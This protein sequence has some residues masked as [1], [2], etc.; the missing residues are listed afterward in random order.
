VALDNERCGGPRARAPAIAR[1]GSVCCRREPR[2]RARALRDAA[3]ERGPRGA[4]GEVSARGGGRAVWEKA[5]TVC[6]YQDYLNLRL[7]GPRP[8][9]LRVRLVWG[10]GRDLSD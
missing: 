4:V 6:E 7:T 9:A 2:S 8:R 1:R 5:A 10:L 3:R